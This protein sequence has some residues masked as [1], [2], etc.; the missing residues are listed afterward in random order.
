MNVLS[1][2][3]IFAA[4]FLAVFG[5]AALPGLRLL[6]GAQVDLLPA[7]MVYGALNSNLATV[8]ALAIFGG[9]CF[10]SAAG[11]GRLGDGNAEQHPDQFGQCLDGQ[12][13]QSGT[14]RRWRLAPHGR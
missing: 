6:L 5:E 8:T 1:T 4:A 2:I 11:Y 3:L 10:D 12:G 13:I 7:I 9:L 14:E